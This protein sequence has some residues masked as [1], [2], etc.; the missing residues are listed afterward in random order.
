MVIIAWA[1]AT[2][3]PLISFYVIYKLDL[4]RIGAFHFII[5]CFAWGIVAFGLATQINPAVRDLLGVADEA[6]VR[7]IAPICEEILKGLI[8]IYLVRRP[9]FA[10]FVDGAIYG[11]AVGIGFAIV[12]NYSFLLGLQGSLL[13]GTA[14]G[15]VLSTN[16]VHATGSALIGMA[17]GFARFQRLTSGILM[18][19]AGLLLAMGVHLA[20]NNLTRSL[21][22]GVLLLLYAV[23]VGFSGAVFIA[24]AIRRGLAEEKTWI[25]ETLGE[26]DRVTAGEAAIVHRLA[27]ARQILAPVVTRFG[28]EK[29]AQIERFLLLQ[30][31]LGILRKTLEKLSDE[32]M[33][34][35]V[36]AQMEKLRQEMN[37]ARQAVGAYCML[38]LRHTFPLDASPLWG[39]LETVIQERM[40]S[41]P[42]TNGPTLWATLDERTAAASQHER[43][44]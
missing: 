43:D 7:F 34:R 5:L 33:V 35:A 27:D 41:G 12:E 16:L 20:F 15:R 2:A 31:R 29:G 1:I 14:V 22:G 6:R 25:E 44:E 23:A 26:A 21:V 40:A 8:L 19:L 17:L 11:F 37:A 13:I 39:R 28:P 32:K 3:V 30:A 18:L 10:Y 38:Y 42:A 4:Y 9:N 24:F 36:E